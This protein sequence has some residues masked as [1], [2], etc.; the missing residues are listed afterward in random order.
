MYKEREIKKRVIFFC[1]CCFCCCCVFVLC[2]VALR[3]ICQGKT[4]DPWDTLET[5]DCLL[6]YS[7]SRTLTRPCERLRERLQLVV[8]TLRVA[9]RPVTVFFFFRSFVLQRR[10]QAVNAQK[11]VFRARAVKKVRGG[12]GM[13]HCVSRCR[14]SCGACAC[15]AAL[16]REWELNCSLST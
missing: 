9:C 15:S 13:A 6:N 8:K 1:C 11:R 5:Q 12:A 14:D 16:R 2:P 4:S 10:S 3:L 7:A